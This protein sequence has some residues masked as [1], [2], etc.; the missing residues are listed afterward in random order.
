MKTLREP[1]PLKS[2]SGGEKDGQLGEPVPH[3][4]ALAEWCRTQAL[5]ALSVQYW[6]LNA[7][8]GE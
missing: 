3:I 4:P 7:W 1:A 5:A 8:P 2:P 6:Y